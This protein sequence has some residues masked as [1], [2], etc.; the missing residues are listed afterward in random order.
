MGEPFD[1]VKNLL[2]RRKHGLDLSFGAEVLRDRDLIEAP[3]LS[4]DYGEER[5]NALGMI[6]GKVY[7]VTYTERAEGVRFIS[8]READK[9][10]AAHYF[11]ANF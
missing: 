2:N 4:M 5:F 8:V 7:A 9:R 11:Q 6:N 3:D 1:P 10:E